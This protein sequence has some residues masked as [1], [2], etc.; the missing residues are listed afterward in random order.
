MATTVSE[1]PAFRIACAG[2]SVQMAPSGDRISEWGE[3]GCSATATA[4]EP[5]SSCDACSPLAQGA[6]A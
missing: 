6:R 3:V 2:H 5:D 4:S 1:P